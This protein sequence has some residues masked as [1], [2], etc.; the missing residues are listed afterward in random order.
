M[1]RTPLFVSFLAVILSGCHGIVPVWNGNGASVVDVRTLRV[2]GPNAV[3]LAKGL[4]LYADKVEYG[5]KSHRTGRASG[6]VFLEAGPDSPYGVIFQYGYAGSATFDLRERE[7]VLADQPMLEWS[8]M[9]QAA[10][11]SYTTMRVHWTLLTCEVGVDGP[12]RTDFSKSHPL[13]AGVTVGP[14]D[15]LL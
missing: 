11:A 3:L 9:I 13:P 4:T 1:L 12:T 7:V 14:L 2:R 15:P 10:T 6:R 5:D 8:H